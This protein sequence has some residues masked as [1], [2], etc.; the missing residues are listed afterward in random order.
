MFPIFQTQNE[1]GAVKAF[2][3]ASHIFIKKLL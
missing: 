2:A 1:H 3:Y